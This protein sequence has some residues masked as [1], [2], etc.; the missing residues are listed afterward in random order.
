[1]TALREILFPLPSARGF[2]DENDFCRACDACSTVWHYYLRSISVNR[3]T[4]LTC[5]LDLVHTR[6][7]HDATLNYLWEDVVGLLQVKVK[8][9]MDGLIEAHL[10]EVEYE[11]QLANILESP[12]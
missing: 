9:E 8:F 6:F 7:E 2:E 3:Y 1:M 10:V 11:V 12:V 5:S 4:V